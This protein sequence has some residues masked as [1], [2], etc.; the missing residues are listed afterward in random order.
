MCASR[1]PQNNL[2]PFASL[3]VGTATF[4]GVL[5][6]RQ[7]FTTQPTLGR[8]LERQEPFPSTRFCD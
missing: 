1:K 4:S 7:V 6:L 8:F 3:I 5:S 2:M